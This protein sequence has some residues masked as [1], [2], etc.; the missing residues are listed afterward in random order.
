MSDETREE[1][2]GLEPAKLFRIALGDS[3]DDPG[4]ARRAEDEGGQ[5]KWRW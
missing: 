1:I 5:H 3:A 4:A 2:E